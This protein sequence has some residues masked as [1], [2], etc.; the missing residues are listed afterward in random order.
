MEINKEQNR[1]LCY[2][3]WFSIQDHARD[4]SYLSR[5]VG[6]AKTSFTEQDLQEFRKEKSK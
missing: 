4:V 6:I 3:Y 1:S 2:A 5:I